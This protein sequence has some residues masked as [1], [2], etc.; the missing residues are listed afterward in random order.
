[1]NSQQWREMQRE[2]EAADRRKRHRLLLLIVG[3]LVGMFCVAALCG[4]AGRVNPERELPK[5]IHG[6]D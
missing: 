2:F 3:V 6:N 5:I 1:M 4:C